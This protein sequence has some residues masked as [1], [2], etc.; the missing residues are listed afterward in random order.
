ML[1]EIIAARA[2]KTCIWR[3]WDQLH[4]TTEIAYIIRRCFR[5][6]FLRKPLGF[7]IPCSP[8]SSSFCTCDGR[9]GRG[10][11]AVVYLRPVWWH[12]A[13]SVAV[14]NRPTNRRDLAYFDRC[15]RLW[16]LLWAGNLCYRSRWTNPIWH[17]SRDKRYGCHSVTAGGKSLF[18]RWLISRYSLSIST[19]WERYILQ[20]GITF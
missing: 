14:V 6:R 17:T 15:L 4:L 18:K 19:V 20:T 8:N 3:P 16:V 2:I 1:W 12:G 11:S 5:L 7:V 10:K 9:R 13:Q